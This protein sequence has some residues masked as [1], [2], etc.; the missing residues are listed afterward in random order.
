MFYLQNLLY[1]DLLEDSHWGLYLLKL[2]S[3]FLEHENQESP[4]QDLVVYIAKQVQYIPP[5]EQFMN[6]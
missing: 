5:Y 1:T 2:S 4:V 3:H 6:E